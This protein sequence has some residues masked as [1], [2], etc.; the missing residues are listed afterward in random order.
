MGIIRH[1]AFALMLANV[2]VAAS[3]RAEWIDVDEDL[4]YLRESAAYDPADDVLGVYVLDF[5]DGT[6]FLLYFRCGSATTWFDE[7]APG[8]WDALEIEYHPLRD[9]L[10]AQRETL[11]FQDF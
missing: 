2:A 5:M 10:C 8:R 11:P 4:A 7:P 9:A 1:A 3:A 6:D